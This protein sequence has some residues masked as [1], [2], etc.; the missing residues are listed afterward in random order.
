[1]TKFN[2]TRFKKAMAAILAVAMIGQ[3]C[4]YVVSAEDVLN[5]DAAVQEQTVQETEQQTADI[6][7]VEE[8]PQTENVEVPQTDSAASVTEV[9]AE[10]PVEAQSTAVDNQSADTP[11]EKP[12][13][14]TE[15]INNE[16][17]DADTETTQGEADSD[18]D[19][20]NAQDNTQDNAQP[21]EEA[22]TATWHVTFAG[23]AAAH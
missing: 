16:S 6:Q 19:T 9:P 2:R 21:Q 23:D 12:E 10:T 4:S 20:E 8:A 18:A 14:S 1:M 3:N 11:V 17:S 7:P 13:E 22:P 5:T 15:A